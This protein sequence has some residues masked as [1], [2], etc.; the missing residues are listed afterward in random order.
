[1]RA[2]L[3]YGVPHINILFILVLKKQAEV[4]SGE[5]FQRHSENVLFLGGIKDKGR[6]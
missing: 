3:C 1:M 6:G 5:Y 2:M 4:T